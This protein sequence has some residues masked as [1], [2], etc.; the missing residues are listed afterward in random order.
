MR[1]PKFIIRDMKNK[2]SVFTWK[3]GGEAGQ[4]QQAAGAIF[5]KVVARR[6]YSSFGYSEFPSL[7]RGGHVTYAVSASLKPVT[8]MYRTV[9]LLVALNDDTVKMHIG[10]VSEDGAVI[11]DSSR[12]LE[13][14]V[15]EMSKGKNRK[16]YPL[17]IEK[18]LEENKLKKI[19]SNM[20]AVGSSLGI[21]EYDFE[22]VN[23]V[24]REVFSRKGDDVVKM[25][26]VAIDAGYKYAQEHFDPKDFPYDLK[27]KA[28][29]K[30]KILVTC[31]QAVALGAIASGCRLYVAY[32]MSPSSSILHA[33]AAWSKKTGV[34]VYQPEDEIAG[35]HVMLGAM[36]AGTRAMTGTSGGG[37][38]L[39]AEAVALSAMTETPAVFAVCSRPGPATGLPTWTEQGDLKFIVNCS[40]GDFP[41]VVLAPSNPQETFTFT[42]LAFNIAEKYQIPV[43]ILLDKYTSEGV[44]SL[45]SLDTRVKI[46]R[47]KILSAKELSKMKEYFRFK[48]EKDGVSSRAFPGTLGGIHLANSD[49]HDEYGYA[50]EGWHEPMRVEQVDKRARKLEGIKKEL[51]R[52]EHHGPKRAKLTLLGWGSTKN[53]VLEALPLLKDVNYIHIPALWPIDERAIEHALKGVRKLVSMENNFSGQFAHLLRA[54][55]GIK[56]DELL[57]KYDGRQFWPEEII[58]KVKYKI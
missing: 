13:E 6:G 50:I 33:L 52:P 15:R 22:A 19:A 17:P 7:I 58:E 51:P 29:G 20:V 26:E 40:H 46:E 45:D 14:D 48:L 12:I 32:P 1:Q 27:S 53:P 4:G 41:R 36:H 43:F 31:N 25:N 3:I 11:Y 47:G 2:S 8:A 57:L 38:A 28:T 34:L 35:V 39:M 23:A 54:E 44:F 24:I 30:P 49:E 55:T 9:N 16:I 21:L 5:S 18:I 10:E 56:P 42:S 37:F